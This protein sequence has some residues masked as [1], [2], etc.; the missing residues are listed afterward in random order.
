MLR[1]H[2]DLQYLR[3]MLTDVD[4]FVAQEIIILLED[5]N[6]TGPKQVKTQPR[7]TYHDAIYHLQRGIGFIEAILQDPFRYINIPQRTFE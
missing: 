1:Q 4:T 3:M 7:C 2:N 5:I 6:S